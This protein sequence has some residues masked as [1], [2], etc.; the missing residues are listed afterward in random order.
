MKN[1]KK[2]TDQN[3]LIAISVVY[4]L[5]TLLFTENKNHG[6]VLS[7][8]VFSEDFHHRLIDYLSFAVNTIVSRDDFKPIRIGENLVENYK[9]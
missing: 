8:R 9:G 5:Q 7:I 4:F 6:R 1:F 2:K 3:P